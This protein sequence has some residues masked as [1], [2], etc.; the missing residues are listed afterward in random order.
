VRKL[1]AIARG[2]QSVEMRKLAVRRLGE[3]QDPEAHKFLEEL[4]K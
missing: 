2:D 4:L 1:I 3:S